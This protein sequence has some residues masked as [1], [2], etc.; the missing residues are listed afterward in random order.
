MIGAMEDMGFF[1]KYKNVIVI[2]VVMFLLLVTGTAIGFFGMRHIQL[3]KYEQEAVTRAV[4]T[5]IEGF[6]KAL[7]AGDP[8]T[9]RLYC[10]EEV[11]KGMGLDMMDAGEYRKILLDGLSVK[12]EDL[13]EETL[14]SLDALTNAMQASVVTGTSY[15]MDE[16]VIGEGD[17][18]SVTATLPIRIKGCGSLANLDF[19]GEISLANVSVAN[20]TSE[21]QKRLMDLYEKE[22][23]EA[24]REDL[25]THE[26]GSLFSAMNGQAKKAAALERDW[27]VTFTIGKDEDGNVTAATIT[28]AAV[29]RDEP[30]EGSNEESGEGSKDESGKESKDESDKKPRD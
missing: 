23:E 25:E 1:E 10:S 4:K 19:S 30:G 21:N 2:F 3:Q 11:A 28:N 13:D 5:D 17:D 18:S 29:V 6:C 16:L 8:E 20:Y 24:V 27:K 26:L 15:D 12:E 14:K 9:A 7:E 22:G